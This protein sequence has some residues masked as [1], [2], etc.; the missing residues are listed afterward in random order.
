L[1]EL[2]RQGA[3][4]PLNPY[5][6]PPDWAAQAAVPGYRRAL[7]RY[8]GRCFSIRV[9]LASTQP[10]PL[11]LVESLVGTLSSATG[12]ARAVQVAT[13]ELDQAV[14]EFRVLGA[15]WLPSTYQAGLPAEPD[16]LDRL[17]HVLADAE[18]AASVLSLPVHWPG[19]PPVFDQLGS[20]LPEG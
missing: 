14:G 6:V 10:V 9:A 13:I 20:P 5:P 16:A 17:L 12:A 15:P 8:A 1:E 18:E 11:T 2:A 4:S 3:P 19:M 7:M